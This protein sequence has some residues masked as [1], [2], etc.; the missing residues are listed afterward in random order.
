[1]VIDE[2]LAL[3]LLHPELL[4]VLEPAAREH[5][6]E[7]AVEDRRRLWFRLVNEGA[8]DLQMQQPQFAVL[9]VPVREQ[10]NQRDHADDRQ[11]ELCFACAG[12][13]FRR[14]ARVSISGDDDDWRAQFACV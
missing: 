4:G 7:H 3:G 14:R 2:V 6:I 5:R 12:G 8:A 9:L 10:R 11:R 13:I 1:M